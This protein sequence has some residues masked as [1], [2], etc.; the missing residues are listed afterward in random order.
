MPRSDWS[1]VKN[2]EVHLPTVEE[3]AAI[4]ATLSDTNSEIDALDAK[5]AK[6]RQLKQGMMQELLSGRFRLV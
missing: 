3:Q 6:T 1:V 4:A 2:Y 5:L